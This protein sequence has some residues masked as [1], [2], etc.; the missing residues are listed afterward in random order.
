MR[1]ESEETE[2]SGEFGEACRSCLKYGDDVTLAQDPFD[3]MPAWMCESCRE[4]MQ[5]IFDDLLESGEPESV[6][7]AE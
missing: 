5:L 6:F 4:S 1:M 3:E 2:S 7:G